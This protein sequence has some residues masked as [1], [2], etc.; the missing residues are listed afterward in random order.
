MKIRD[1]HR[2]NCLKVTPNSGQSPD[3]LLL[4]SI[5]V[6]LKGTLYCYLLVLGAEGPADILTWG[7][8]YG[9][10]QRAAEAGVI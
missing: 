8:P 10:S 7:P 3:Y 9:F 6:W 1:G 5:I 4:L 2:I